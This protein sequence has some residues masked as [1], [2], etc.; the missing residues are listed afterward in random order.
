MKNYLFKNKIL[1]FIN[2]ILISLVCVLNIWVAFTL[3]SI[4]DCAYNSSLNKLFNVCIFV[5]IFLLTRRVVAFL[6][7]LLGNK[8]LY[9]SMLILKQDIFKSIM[10]RNIKLFKDENSAN[11]ISTLTNDMKLVENDYFANGLIIILYIIMFVLGLISMISINPIICLFV[12]VTSILPVIPSFL[13]GKKLGIKNKHY[14]DSLSKFTIKIKDLFSGFEVIKGFNIE[15]KANDDYNMVNDECEYAKYNY[16]NFKSFVNIFSQYLG[17]IVFFGTTIIGVYFTI[18]GKMTVGSVIA[19]TQLMNC[20]VNPIMNLSGCITKLKAINPINEKI[21]NLINNKNINDAGL[22]KSIFSSSI[23]FDNVKFE[24]NNDKKVLNGLTFEVEKGEKCA[25][26]GGSGSGKSTLLLL[27]LRFYDSYTGEITIDGQKVTDINYNSLYNLISTIQQNVFMF[28]D[29]IENNIILYNNYDS[30]V[31]ND[32]ISKSGLRKLVDSLPKREKSLVG[33]NGSNL[34]GGEKQ[35]IAIARALIKNTPILILDEATSSLDNENAYN[36]ENSILSLDELTC[37]VVTHKL[38]EEILSKYDKIIVLKNGQVEEIGKF[39]EL[40]NNQG[41][42]YSLY[43]IAG[44]N[45]NKLM[46]E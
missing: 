25:I 14:S 29:T 18:K 19:A 37:L 32:V 16:S 6:C 28:D 1:L 34:S 4:I 35:R 27:L 5:I 36:I 24:Y 12:T 15:S 33:E 8:Y 17:D 26:V 40:V 30:K 46:A 45:I 42:F 39:D 11:Y 2:V 7:E 38:N 20:I 10:Q 9:K 41:Y 21:I 31:I 44:T 22:N 23:K 3:E 13:F 43:N